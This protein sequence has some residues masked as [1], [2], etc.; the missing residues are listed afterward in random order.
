MNRQEDALTG[1]PFEQ[2]G[3]DELEDLENLDATARQMPGEYAKSSTFR[4]D[5]IT[6]RTETLER[7]IPLLQQYSAELHPNKPNSLN[8]H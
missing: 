7:A 6:A 2:Y 8:W 1:C 3:C 4:D 5:R